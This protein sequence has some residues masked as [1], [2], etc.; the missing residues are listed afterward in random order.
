MCTKSE[1]IISGLQSIIADSESTKRNAKAVAKWLRSEVVRMDAEI[2]ALKER[3]N[4]YVRQARMLDGGEVIRLNEG[5]KLPKTTKAPKPTKPKPTPDEIASWTK[6]RQE[7]YWKRVECMNRNRQKKK[8]YA[9]QEK[10]TETN[11]SGGCI[12]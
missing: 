1:S 3:R 8:I 12:N 7:Q 2:S 6:E 10:F 9:L 4:E 11:L 5:E